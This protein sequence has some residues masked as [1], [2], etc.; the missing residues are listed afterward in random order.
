MR[1]GQSQAN[2]QGV[3]VS[4]PAIGTRSHGLTE[5]G[6]MQ[7][8]LSAS[9]FEADSAK[10][11][12]YSSDFLRARQSASI[13]HDMLTP[14]YPVVLTTLLRERYFG[15]LDGKSDTAYD[16]VW[17]RDALD[18]GHCTQGVESATAVVARGTRLLE[19][20]EQKYQGETFL[21]IAHGDVLQ[22]LQTVFEQV[23]PSQHRQLRHL[24]VA[25]VRRLN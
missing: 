7:V 25:E 23:P 18:P 11:R 13:V 4:M 1:H 10:L 2:D 17:S 15:E 14:C 6:R 3:I 16:E 5:T 9:S 24:D 8:R 12:I 22:L 21:L 19:S 20:L